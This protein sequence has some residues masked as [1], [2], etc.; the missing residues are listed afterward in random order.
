MSSI[1]KFS[2]LHA[3]YSPKMTTPEGLK[4]QLALDQYGKT[5][6][7]TGIDTNTLVVACNT[8]EDNFA[9]D[10]LVGIV[11]S[12]LRQSGMQDVR[13][14]YDSSGGALMSKSLPDTA[15]SRRSPFL[16]AAFNHLTRNAFSVKADGEL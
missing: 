12:K 14:V 15:N 16:W 4:L 5:E 3:I 11:V 10:A 6:T 9:N 7:Y 13:Y 2:G 8:G 1:P